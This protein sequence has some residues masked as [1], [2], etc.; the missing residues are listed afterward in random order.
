[1]LKYIHMSHCKSTIVYL[2]S[3]YSSGS[4]TAWTV[5]ELEV[6]RMHFAL[7]VVHVPFG[8]GDIGISTAGPVLSMIVR[9]GF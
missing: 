9:K 4:R 6:V 1:M 3:C 2:W 8:C 5:V 7:E